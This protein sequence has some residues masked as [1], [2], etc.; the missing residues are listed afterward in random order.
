MEKR[1]LVNEPHKGLIIFLRI[2]GIICLATGII[3]IGITISQMGSF[4]FSTP[5]LPF[6]GIPLIFVGNV[7]LMFGFMKKT[8]SFVASQNA[9]VQKDVANYI[10]DGT[11]EEMGKTA[12]E[13]FSQASMAGAS[14]KVSKKEF[15]ICPQCGEKNDPD[16][17]FCDKCGTSLV[18]VCRSCG[19]ENDADATYCDNCGSRLY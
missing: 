13:I 16:A 4:N 17:K 9:P 1:N 2:F 12:K 15:R 19:E 3:M 11:R 14:S 7:C 10:L 8:N 6:V 5:F 18:K